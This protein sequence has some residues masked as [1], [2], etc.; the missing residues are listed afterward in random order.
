MILVNRHCR[1]EA[2]RLARS[3]E[4]VEIARDPGFE[5]IYAAAMSF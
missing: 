2:G 4:Y 3:I 1:T 5:Q